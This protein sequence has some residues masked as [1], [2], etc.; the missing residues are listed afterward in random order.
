MLQHHCVHMMDHVC[1]LLPAW[2]DMKTKESRR[3]VETVLVME[4]ALGKIRPH[5]LS[6]DRKHTVR[7]H[8]I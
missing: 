2:R 1:S 4:L 3:L 7:R 5:G 6:R 8:D